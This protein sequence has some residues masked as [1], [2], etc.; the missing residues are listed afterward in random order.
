[1]SH[2]E[3]LI[4]WCLSQHGERTMGSL[5]EL[6]RITPSHLS[7]IASRLE[8]QGWLVREQDP[9][10]ARLTIASLTEAGV[11][12]Y[13]EAVSLYRTT[14]REHVFGLLTEEQSRQLGTVAG[15]IARSLDN[16]VN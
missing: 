4:L 16:R 15:S 1:M 6:S 3:F 7:R 5:A 14:L 9:A 10:D 12:K 13:A 2:H 11:L 8:G